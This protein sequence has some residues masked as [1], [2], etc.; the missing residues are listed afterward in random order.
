MRRANS[1]GAWA[2]FCSSGRGILVSVS[3]MMFCLGSVAFPKTASGITHSAAG[4]VSVFGNALASVPFGTLQR[5]AIAR[6]KPYVGQLRAEALNPRQHCAVTSEANRGDVATFFEQGKFVGYQVGSG[7]GLNTSIQIKN[8]PTIGETA[9]AVSRQY[10][11]AFSTSGEQ[12]GSWTLKVATGRLVGLLTAPP[13]AKHP[14][15]ELVA[16]GYLGCMAP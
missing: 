4:D 1:S 2:A 10:G 12:G 3:L 15:I 6:L 9:Q 13:T 11:A 16:A 14:Q 7:M 8:A 5:D